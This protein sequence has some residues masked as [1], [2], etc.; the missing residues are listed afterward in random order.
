MP[1]V[2]ALVEV[3]PIPLVHPGQSSVRGQNRPKDLT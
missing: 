3:M 1:A 2:G